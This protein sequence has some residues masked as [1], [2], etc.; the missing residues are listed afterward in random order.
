MAVGRPPLQQMKE[1]QGRWAIGVT[2]PYGAEYVYYCSAPGHREGGMEG[3]MTI[4]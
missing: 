2:V 3:T 4:V 1:R